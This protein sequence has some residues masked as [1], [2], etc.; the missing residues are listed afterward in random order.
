MNELQNDILQYIHVTKV[1]EENRTR[2]VASSNRGLTGY[3]EK[4]CK[5]SLKK[6]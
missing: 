5:N 6:K 4:N 2:R 1:G 3:D